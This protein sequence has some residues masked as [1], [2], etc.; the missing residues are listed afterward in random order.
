LQVFLRRSILWLFLSIAYHAAFNMAALIAAVRLGAVGAEGVL[1]VF[2]LL[3]LFVIFRLRGP[4]PTEAEPSP[5]IE[6]LPA[7]AID[8]RPTAEALDRSRYS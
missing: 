8:L 1:A 4:E 3:S 6:P 2:S 7:A 5:F